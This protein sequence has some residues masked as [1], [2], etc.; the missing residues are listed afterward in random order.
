MAR[1][2]GRFHNMFV[3]F[4]R[5]MA[6]NRALTFLYLLDG[7]TEAICT[8]NAYGFFWCCHY[9]ISLTAP[10]LTTAA[11]YVQLWLL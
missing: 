3:L 11:I 4:I 5:Y 6:E 8:Q 2:K 9:H 10:H 1:E 7:N